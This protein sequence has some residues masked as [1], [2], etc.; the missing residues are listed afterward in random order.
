[1]VVARIHDVIQDRLGTEWLPAAELIL[2]SSHRRFRSSLNALA[3]LPSDSAYSGLASATTAAIGCLPA[4]REI[5]MLAGTGAAGSI[6][7]VSEKLQ[8]RVSQASAAVEVDVAKFAHLLSLSADE[9]L[10]AS[11]A[12]YAAN[13]SNK[14]DRW[15]AAAVATFGL[16]VALAAVVVLRA[17]S[18]VAA[19]EDLVG[20]IGLSLALAGL[21]GYLQHQSALHRLREGQARALEMKLRTLGPFSAG[22]PVDDAAKLRAAVG[23]ALF[24]NA[25]P[26]VEANGAHLGEAGLPSTKK[27]ESKP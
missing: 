13:Q 9:T 16:A 14:A 11:Y 18:D 12:R 19:P 26:L 20:R 23:L 3:N 1:M 4:L 21:G 17:L 25:N 6:L 27:D 7:A 5:E 8:Q 15:R 24:A 22:L 10:A 2:A